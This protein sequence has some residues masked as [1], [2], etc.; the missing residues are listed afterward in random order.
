MTPAG[1]TDSQPAAHGANLPARRPLRHEFTLIELLVV[2]GLVAVIALLSYKFFSNLQNVWQH[3]I[4]R[5]NTH[6]DAR[7]ALG[8]LARDLQAA[9]A[10]TDDRPGFDIRFHQPSDTELWFV[11]DSSADS[12]VPC[13]LVE[14]GYRLQDG[15]LERA[16]VDQ[17]NAAWNIYGDRDN[18]DD[19]DGY[20]LVVD[21]V[22]SLQFACSDAAR[23]P[24]V[25][26]QLSRLPT[27][28]CIT[29]SVM[30]PRD[31]MRWR[32][33]PTTERPTFEKR[34]ARTFWRS[35]RPR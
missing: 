15:R 32:A 7:L 33:L 6:E 27:M 13:S 23:E 29:L 9:I 10:C 16:S 17:S 3:A 1:L 4:G 2:A 5:T 34:A 8:L 35:V 12:T 19:Q 31:L 24:L 14:I 22:T 21:G 30:D 18:A 25:P 11:C 20:R 26:N 28:I